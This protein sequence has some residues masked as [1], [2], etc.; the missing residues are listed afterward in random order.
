MFYNRTSNKKLKLPEK[1]RAAYERF[2]KNARNAQSTIRSAYEEGVTEGKVKG[3]A[4]GRVEGEIK[5]KTEMVLNFH[6]LGISV[7]QI[8]AGAK[9]SLEEVETILANS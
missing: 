3:L 5:A 9:L 7:E 8:A 6:R 2:I 4:E 1:E